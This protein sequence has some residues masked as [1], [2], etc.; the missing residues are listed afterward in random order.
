M[1]LRQAQAVLWN[2]LLKKIQFLKLI[3][4]SKIDNTNKEI[5]ITPSASFDEI[6]NAVGNNITIKNKKGE[7]VTDSNKISTGSIVNDEFVI[8]KKGDANADGVVNTFDYIRIMNYIMGNKT[9]SEDEKLAADANADGKVNS[10]DYI[11]IMNYIMGNKK[12]EL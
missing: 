10:F 3:L 7:I 5:A 4:L 1:R 11:R 8:I 6:K 9:L 2:F 12:I